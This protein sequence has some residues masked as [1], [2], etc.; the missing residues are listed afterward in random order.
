MNVLKPLVLA[1]LLAAPAIAAG[2]YVR[3][4][5]RTDAFRSAVDAIGTRFRDAVISTGVL[6]VRAL[7][8]VGAADGCTYAELSKANVDLVARIARMH[9]ENDLP[10]DLAGS[11]R[12]KAFAPADVSRAGKILALEVNAHDPRSGEDFKATK[13]LWVLVNKLGLKA[14]RGVTVTTR[15][16]YGIKDDSRHFTQMLFVNPESRRALALYMIE[17]RL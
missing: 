15:V 8:L 14:G 7:Q 12:A 10:A 9:Y 6:D 4:L 2:P 16:K 13:Q 5:P 3:E 1:L 17:G 11:T